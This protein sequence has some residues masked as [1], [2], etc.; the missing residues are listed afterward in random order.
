MFDSQEFWDRWELDCAAD[1]TWPE[2]DSAVAE[3]RRSGAA[4]F[5]E[6]RR[7]LPGEAPTDWDGLNAPPADGGVLWVDI[8]IS[9]ADLRTL[10]QILPWLCPGI[11]EARITD[12][13]FAELEPQLDP[14]VPAAAISTIR[15]FEGW[16]ITCWHRQRTHRMDAG[17][18]QAT[19]RRGIHGA[20]EERW[21]ALGAEGA[22][23]AGDLASLFFDEAGRH[24]GDGHVVVNGRAR[25]LVSGPA[26]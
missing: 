19:D 4:D 6:I 17:E 21:Q 22:R 10:Q 18:G 3:E 9:R 14:D 24:L 2:R 5:L 20:V 16:L 26:V 8:D 15:S 13:F 12:L 23:S 11:S 25:P 1:W 7:C